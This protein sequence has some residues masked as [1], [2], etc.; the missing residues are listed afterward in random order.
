M[1]RIAITACLALLSCRQSLE[2]VYEIGESL[3]TLEVCI[4]AASSV[5]DATAARRLARL[6]LMRNDRSAA[7]SPMTRRIARVVSAWPRNERDALLTELTQLDSFDNVLNKDT[8]EAVGPPPHFAPARR[9]VGRLARMLEWA[10]AS[11]PVGPLWMQERA[12]WRAAQPAAG[13][14]SV[15]STKWRHTWA[16]CAN[17]TETEHPQFFSVDL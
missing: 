11:L 2:P 3:F 7:Q 6:G 14:R 9:S 5:A 4:S 15:F 13:G 10:H 1:L 8:L 16:L 12:A 17:V